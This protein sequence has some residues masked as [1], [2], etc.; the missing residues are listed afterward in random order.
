MR[1]KTPIEELFYELYGFYPS[2]AGQA[3]EMLGTAAYYLL[4]AEDAKV[5]QYVRGTYSDTCHQLDGLVTKDGKQEI[6]EAKD[7]TVRNNKVGLAEI[8][9]LEG[10]LVDLPMEKGVFISATD[11]SKPAQ[12]YAKG[13]V[14]NPTNKPIELYEVKEAVEEDEEGRIK[15]IIVRMHVTAPDFVKG[16]YNPVF[17]HEAYD[18]LETDGFLGKRM[19]FVF[20]NFYDTQGNKKET[21]YNIT[22]GISKRVAPDTEDDLIG[23]SWDM[24]GCYYRM[25]NGKLYEMAKIDYKVPINHSDIEFVVEKGGKPRVLIRSLDGS[26]DKLLTDEELK[27]IRFDK[28][29]GLIVS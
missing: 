29:G 25:D 13:S 8:E 6:I 15:K 12:K 19:A 21:F 23:G 14:K 5:N 4:G 22:K 1:D 7:Y 9:K 3:L 17:T 24:N 26:V 28:E 20:E 27:K 18:Q 16:T 2:K 10:S 11:Y